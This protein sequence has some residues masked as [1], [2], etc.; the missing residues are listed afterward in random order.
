[1]I[2]DSA[3][4]RILINVDSFFHYRTELQMKPGGYQTSA[5]QAPEETALLIPYMWYRRHSR[6]RCPVTGFP[7][8]FTPGARFRDRAALDHEGKVCRTFLHASINSANF[9]AS[10]AQQ[11][12]WHDLRKW[13]NHVFDY[14]TKDHSAAYSETVISEF[15]A[16]F[17]AGRTESKQEFHEMTGTR[18]KELLNRAMENPDL[19]Q[20]LEDLKAR[21]TTCPITSA[22]ITKKSRLRPDHGHESGKLRLPLPGVVNLFTGCVEAPAKHAAR[23]EYSGPDRNKF[24]AIFRRH[25]RRM[26]D[27]M[28][29]ILIRRPKA[30]EDFIAAGRADPEL[31][32]IMRAHAEGERVS[33]E[34]VVKAMESGVLKAATD[35]LDEFYQ[36]QT[37]TTQERME[38][39]NPDLEQNPMKGYFPQLFNSD[40]QPY[41]TKGFEAF[42]GV[43]AASTDEDVDDDDD[44]RHFGKVGKRLWSEKAA[45]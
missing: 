37:P 43:G 18:H 25:L 44:E 33:F 6:I 1:M 13:G 41:Y 12:G 9:V 32:A 22:P 34:P 5:T 45:V 8:Y 27:A 3:R 38:R 10:L 24:L 17:S 26:I 16:V 7:L 39:M 29:D 23:A 36:V 4:C 31:S 15:N 30:I 35:A 42:N 21:M 19:V 28:V 14:L 20:E 2:R 11:N 40:G